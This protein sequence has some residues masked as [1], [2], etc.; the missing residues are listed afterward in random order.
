[1]FTNF[2]VKF[3][4]YDSNK[5]ISSLEKEKNWKKEK[6]KTE[7]KKKIITSNSI[8]PTCYSLSKILMLS[9]SNL[10]FLSKLDVIVNN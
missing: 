4:M 5:I 7:K 2:E 8:I 1:M 3:W 10:K 9:L 6:K